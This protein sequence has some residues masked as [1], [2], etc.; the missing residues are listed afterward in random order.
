MFVQKRALHIDLQIDYFSIGLGGGGGGGGGVVDTRTL[1]S[2]N[3]NY[4]DRSM[5]L[6]LPITK[7]IWDEN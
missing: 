7:L 3:C 2:L 5:V 6:Y 1:N 4:I